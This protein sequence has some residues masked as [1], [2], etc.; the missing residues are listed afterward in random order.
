MSPNQKE[1]RA[2]TL[3]GRVWKVRSLFE[4]E[5][6]DR[7]RILA[8]ELSALGTSEAVVTLAREAATDELRHAELCEGLAAHFG[9][10][11]Q[12]RPAIVFRR[13]APAHLAP[14]ERL[15]YEVVAMSC[16]TETLSTALL[17]TLVDRARDTLAKQTMKSILRDEVKHSQLGW[18]FL[19]EQHARGAPDCVSS[20]LGPMLEAT[21]GDELYATNAPTDP[22]DDALAGLGAL[23]RLERRRIVRE[24]LE[25]VVFPGLERFGIDT[26]PGRRW[27]RQRTQQ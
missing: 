10:P 2:R 13:V 15:L 18:A 24:T 25:L 22:S 14:G 20:H 23:E 11:A 16:V 5:A 4:L 26:A 7:F 9:E 6:A 1:N 8:S 27:L 19:A 17:G 3:A 21:M 12:A